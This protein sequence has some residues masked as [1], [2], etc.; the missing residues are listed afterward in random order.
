MFRCCGAG[1]AADTEMTTRKIESQLELLR[2]N[3]GRDV[4]V[5]AANR[6][7]K[8]MLFRYQVSQINDN[9]LTIMSIKIELIKIAGPHWSGT[10]PG[11]CG[12]EW[13]TYLL[14]LSSWIN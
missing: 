4:P 13:V 3:Q 7:L 8:Q 14:Y 5:V 12:Q 9:I 6:L 1:T 2:L 10:G 11:R